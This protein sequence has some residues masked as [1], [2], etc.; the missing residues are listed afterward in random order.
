MDDA[1]AICTDRGKEVGCLQAVGDVFQLLSVASKEDG[2]GSR[3]ISNANN[4]ALD[5]WWAIR[6]R[7]ERLIK[8]AVTRGCICDGILVP[9]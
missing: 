4:I 8:A 9:P 2:S 6:C 7:V 1:G 3:S 5:E